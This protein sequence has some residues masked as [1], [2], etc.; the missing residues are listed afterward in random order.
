[1]VKQVL[2]D[3]ERLRSDNAPLTNEKDR[4][5]ADALGQGRLVI[6]SNGG[7]VG[8]GGETGAQGVHINPGFRGG[9][10]DARQGL[11]IGRAHV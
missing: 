5:R 8:P 7:L 3:V 1:M 11:E 4:T 10:F 2:K 9:G 6:G